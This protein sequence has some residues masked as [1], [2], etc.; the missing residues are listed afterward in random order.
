M[1]KII[2]LIISLV[3]L[4]PIAFTYDNDNDPDPG[5]E[6]KYYDDAK[7]MRVK[8]TQGEAY[9]KRSYDDGF[10]EAAVNLPIFEKDTAGTTDGRM[11]V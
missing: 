9:V 1:K 10:E 6:P 2:T 5:V 3:L 4:A 8:H 11:E 7:V